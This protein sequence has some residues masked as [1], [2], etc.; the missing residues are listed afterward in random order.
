[1]KSPQMKKIRLNTL[2]FAASLALI[3]SAA[4]LTAVRAAA[5]AVA[6]ARR[7]RLL[8]DFGWRFAFGS[9]VDARKDFNT[10]TSYFS[11]FAKSGYGD[12]A[13]AADFDDRGWRVLDVPHDWAVEAPF[14][15]HGSHSHGYKSVGRNF[16]ETSVGWYRK[17]FFIPA[18]DRGRRIGVEFDG[19]F[20]DSTVWVNGHYLGREESGY[21]G[22]GWNLTE[23]LNYG[24]DNVIA[25]RA[26]ATMEEGWFYEGAGIYRH[27][28]LV[29]TDPLHV[30]RN[31]S[32]VTSRID[33]ASAAVTARM[34]VINE[35]THAA[36]FEIHQEIVDPDGKMAAFG[37]V[38][39]CRLDARAE[40]EFSVEIAVPDPKLWSIDSPSL[41]RLVTTIRS[42][43]A[44]VDTYETPFGI[45]SI[46]F[47][48]DQGFFL[49][50]KRVELKGMNN[51]QDH[52]GV[53]AAI[54]DALQ[55]YRVERLK[56]FGCNA[57]RCSH[58]PPTPELLEACDRLGMLV[59]D[60]NREMGTSEDQ[61]DHL[62]RLIERDR[63]HPSV[64]L[65][66]LGNEEWGI[67][68]S[69]KGARITETMQAL[70][71]HL[72]P[73]RLCTVGDSGGWD[74]EVPG[75]WR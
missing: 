52:A 41:Y 69:E 4:G 55:R 7:E 20:R 50:G 53:G 70:A 6:P 57:Y 65:W 71:N 62:R 75:R 21:T 35:G 60:E 64:I 23:F 61:L 30:K 73:T 58:N 36:E 8:M 44:E 26:D 17:S 25:V 63:N 46:R 2:G 12:G 22:F 67:E 39:P 10:G 15:G 34:A 74:W 51:H 5:D 66:S 42:G 32:F 24:E 31:G 37:M 45:R 1:M 43:E 16:P 18:S 54:P 9:A 27:V 14:D 19:V 59:M 33:G 49:N 47:D 11:Y 28:W 38:K 29:K 68:S 48:P 13:A 40:G 56:E 3:V 72:D